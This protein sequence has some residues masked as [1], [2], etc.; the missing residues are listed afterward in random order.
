LKQ[1]VPLYSKYLKTTV[2]EENTQMKQ[3]FKR[4]FLIIISIIAVVGMGC[5]ITGCGGSSDSGTST[6]EVVDQSTTVEGID[7]D[8]NGVWQYI[9]EYIEATYTTET[10]R[11][12]LTQYAI[13][14]QNAL[15]DADNKEL[16]IQHA[17]E[18]DKSSTCL[19]YTFG[20]INAYGEAQD[21]LR[22][23]ILNNDERNYAYFTYNDH[24]GGQVFHGIPYD[25]RESAC[26]FD[27]AN[28]SE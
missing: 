17:K 21:D 22:S 26:E 11:A 18:V 27:V 13:S 16:S 19:W 24:L 8:G 25:E 3:I 15:I 14:V 2:K 23:I 12:S 20:S 4:L 10:E 1:V 6:V 28:L 5:G 9:D 7:T